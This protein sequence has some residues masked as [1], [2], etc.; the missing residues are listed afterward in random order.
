MTSEQLTKAR[1]RS[2]ANCLTYL[3]LTYLDLFGLRRVYLGL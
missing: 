2:I 3:D 1:W